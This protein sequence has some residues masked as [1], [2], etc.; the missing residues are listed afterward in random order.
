MLVIT[1]GYWGFLCFPANLPFQVWERWDCQRY[2][3]FPP[4]RKQWCTLFGAEP[5]VQICPDMIWKRVWCWLIFVCSV[6]FCYLEVSQSLFVWFAHTKPSSGWEIS[7]HTGALR[8]SGVPC[9]G[10]AGLAH[11]TEGWSEV[12]WTNLIVCPLDLQRLWI[13]W[14]ALKSSKAKLLERNTCSN[15]TPLNL[16]ILKRYRNFSERSQEKIKRPDNPTSQNFQ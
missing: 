13:L 1:R 4:R 5:V 9:H 8:L 2:Q 12:T 3:W 14:L 6:F 7:V 16:T 15:A 11:R 10:I